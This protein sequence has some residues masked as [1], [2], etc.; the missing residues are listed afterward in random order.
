MKRL[1][2]TFAVGFST[3]PVAV[4]KIGREA[5]YPLVD[6]TGAAFDLSNLWDDLYRPGLKIVRAA[7]GMQ[8]G[9]EGVAFTYASEVGRGTVE[10]ITGPRHDLVQLA[11]DHDAGLEHLVDVAARHGATVLGHGC[12]PLTPPS[13]GL[14]TPK[15]R[16]AVLHKAIGDAWLSFTATASDQTH[17]DISRDEV[18][19]TTNL[20]NL[21]APVFIA[22]CGNS[23]V[24]AGTDADACSWREV[25]MGAI[26]PSNGRH[27]MP[28]EPIE[29]IEDHVGRLCR[30]SHLMHKHTGVP[31]QGEGRFE[32]FLEDYAVD[33][34]DDVYAA[35]LV[36]EHYVWHSARPRSGHGTLEVRSPCQQPAGDP[37]VASALALGVI[38]GAA[39]IGR[40]IEATLGNDA[41][42]I[43]RRWHGQVLTHGLAAPEP[44]SG[45]IEGV[46]ERAKGALRGR[47][48]DEAR[49]LEPLFFRLQKKENPAQV[50]RRVF[51]KGGM[52]ALLNRAAI[53]ASTDG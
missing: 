34:W 27:G 20:G 5:E 12:Q 13:L 3:G 15:P 21:L 52:E 17:V 35:F 38:A 29:S 14:M 7:D 44:A 53:P 11:G 26:E 49:F 25:A 37:M 31:V 19:W 18:A 9:L 33:D 50:A 43:M 46:L 36:H 45:L 2:Q 41:W 24:A 23:G 48:R 6:A 8:V 47:G 42:S 28:I 51:A 32:A 39:E 1:A 4:R 10:L 40:H 16:Y 22:L 30:L